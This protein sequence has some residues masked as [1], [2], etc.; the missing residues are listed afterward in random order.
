MLK[1]LAVFLVPVLL[2]FSC[3]DTTLF[4]PEVDTGEEFSIRTAEEGSMFQ[5]DDGIPVEVQ[6][7]RLGASGEEPA[8]LE[9]LEVTLSTVE[10]E[11]VGTSTVEGETLQEEILPDISVP[12]VAPGEYLLTLV[13]FAD[14]EEV[15]R[16]ERRFFVT[17]GQ[18]RIDGMTAYPPSLHPS[19]SG[20]MRVQ[21]SAPEG[22]DP[23]IRWT[24]DGEV[25]QEGYRSDGTDEVLVKSSAEEGVYPVRVEL[26]PTGPRGNESFPYASST[27]YTSR[28][29]VR[30]TGD[31]SDNDL[32]PESSY[33]SLFH[34]LGNLRDDGA[35][36]EIF[37][38]PREAQQVGSPDLRVV[39]GVFGYYLDGNSGFRVD[40][41]LL[42]VRKGRL[43]AFSVSTRILSLSS[44]SA[45]SGSAGTL[46]ASSALA[47]GEPV[48]NGEGGDLGAA[49]GPEDGGDSHGG[50]GSIETVGPSESGASSDQP[51]NAGNEGGSG[52]EGIGSGNTSAPRSGGGLSAAEMTWP[53]TLFRSRSAD[54][55]MSFLL[56][57]HESGAVGVELSLNGRSDAARSVTDIIQPNEATELVVSLL[58]GATETVVV[59]FVDGDFAWADT[60]GVGTGSRRGT[61]VAAAD[62]AS[63]T[64]RAEETAT[65]DGRTESEL[66]SQVGVNVSESGRVEW[67]HRAGT[68]V[69]SGEDGFVGVIDEF[70]IYFRDENRQPA[71]DLTVFRKAQERNYGDDLVYAAGFERPDGTAELGTEGDIRIE[72]GSLVLPPG[73]S[74]VFPEFLFR[75]QDLILEIETFRDGSAGGAEGGAGATGLGE[76]SFAVHGIMS[77]SGADEESDSAEGDT[78][79]TGADDDPLRI[80]ADAPLLLTLFEGGEVRV[81]EA[82]DVPTE[83]ERSR[84]NPER[85]ELLDA[86]DDTLAV[87]LRHSEGGLLVGDA[88]GRDRVEIPVRDFAGVQLAVR[89]AETAQVSFRIRSVLAFTE[90]SSL[91]RALQRD[92]R[93]SPR[94]EAE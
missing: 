19:S 84:S 63:R 37:D 7:A 27:Q 8:V 74:V 32:S 38:L 58:P 85:L 12:D 28:L 70:G 42:P 3:G 31:L 93:D 1:R 55:E 62:S 15:S 54:G 92:G 80:D 36:V 34:F 78:A 50:E 4:V 83:I 79:G 47:G 14:G 66:D 65:A 60:L 6:A 43:S 86:E 59:W 89:N 18:Y 71:G 56:S 91:S 69:I 25:L 35:R 30:R 23:Y 20:I 57:L 94:R 33:Y 67:E 10:G 53:R 64:E 39:N 40:D 44:G 87:R 2:L 41:F 68:S 72:A 88:A 22:A 26:F 9:R 21:L 75:S 48:A 45:A 82:A 52:E 11:V 49:G 24:L 13:L 73:G 81:P 46:D 29:I 5:V 51:G 17:D 90:N 77:D 76:S 61:D 16:S